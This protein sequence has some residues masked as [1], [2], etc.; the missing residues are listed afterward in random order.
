ME[1]GP[2]FWLL[3]I[4]AYDYD[5]GVLRGT[6]LKGKALILSRQLWSIIRGETVISVLIGPGVFKG[7]ATIGNRRV[8]ILEPLLA[9]MFDPTHMRADEPVPLVDIISPEVIDPLASRKTEEIMTTIRQLVIERGNVLAAEPLMKM[10][11]DAN[12]PTTAYAMDLLKKIHVAHVSGTQRARFILAGTNS[13]MY[14]P[15]VDWYKK[16]KYDEP[17]RIKVMAMPFNKFSSSVDIETMSDWT[18]VEKAG[19][20]GNSGIE[21]IHEEYEQTLGGLRENESLFIYEV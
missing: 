9:L 4:E 21:A 16:R 7:V 19:I 17:A 2:I 12:V 10:R 18:I 6:D 5:V 14:R 20:D 13:P 15:L 1:H 11:T 3:G 8:E